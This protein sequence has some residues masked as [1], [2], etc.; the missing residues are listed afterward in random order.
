MNWTQF[1]KNIGMRVLF[2]PP[3]CRLAEA[4]HVLPE[5]KED[6]LI[7]SITEDD[8]I[9]F[10]NLI[11]GHVAELGKDHI[12]DY[13]SDPSRPKDGF[14]YGFLILKVQVFVQGSN[15]SLRPNSRPGER[16]IPSNLLHHQ[17]QWTPLVKVDASSGIPPN[18]R[19]AT[20]QYRLWSEVPGVPL[21][22][23]IASDA[24]AAFSQEL[25]GPSGVAHLMLV[26]AQTFYVSFSHPKVIYEI[27][28]TGYKF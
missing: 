8:T 14:N 23:R 28:V 22:L 25:S 9:K 20:V 21:L 13:R 6:W 16:V 2:E 17:V 5:S 24:G 19:S 15:V 12:Y 7:E 27:G 4:G 26:E 18:A 11:S 3:V 1:Q 10:R